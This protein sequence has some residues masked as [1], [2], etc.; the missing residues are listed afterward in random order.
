MYNRLI[1]V[2]GSGKS[3]TSL[4]AGILK[5]LGCH[6]P[7]PEVRADAGNPKGFGEP[8]WVVNF[9]SKLLRE[10]RVQ[11][12][13]A[14]PS[15]WALT[16]A[17]AR[18]RG[19][20]RKLEKWLQAEVAKSDHVVI[21]DPRLCWFIPAWR[22]AGET[23]ATPCFVTLLRHP[24]EVI[25]SKKTRYGEKWNPNARTAGWINTMLYTERATRGDRRAVV[26]YDDLLTDA[27]ATVSKVSEEMELSFIERPTPVQMRDAASLVD[28][29]LNRSRATWESLEVDHRLVELAED[30]AKALDQAAAASL[31]EKEVREGLD[32]LRQRYI[33]LYRFA[34]STAQFSIEARK[35]ALPVGSATAVDKPSPFSADARRKLVRRLKRKSRRTLYQ[36][37]AGGDG[38]PA[39]GENNARKGD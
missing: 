27:M 3:G 10:A 23:V 19:P 37:R 34:E 8:A 5:A 35:P 24:L 39:G 32:E 17:A 9:H 29:A 13:D 38:A 22:R 30:V 6:V 31:D 21:K 1:L 14:R 33:D 11:T 18:D 16:A 20:E 15:A 4:F 36:I 26:R 2:A 7:Q 25:E 12:A 28:P